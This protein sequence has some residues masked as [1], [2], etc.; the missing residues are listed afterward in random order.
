[1]SFFTS[2][3]GLQASQTDMDTI[4]HNLANVSTTGYKRA[5]AVFEDLMY[6]NLRQAGAATSEQTQLP[7]G[8]QVGLGV[9]AAAIFSSSPLVIRLPWI[10]SRSGPSR[11]SAATAFTRSHWPGLIHHQ[12]AAHQ[13]LAVAGFDRTICQRVVVDLHESEAQ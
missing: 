10:T 6:Q 5:N 13:V 3:S 4:S 8:L 1:M 12:G 11:P 2:L 9:R 7:T